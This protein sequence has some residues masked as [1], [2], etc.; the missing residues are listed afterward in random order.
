[1]CNDNNNNNNNNNNSI[2]IALLLPYDR[3]S[4]SLYS[5]KTRKLN[6]KVNSTLYQMVIMKQT[7]KANNCKANIYKIT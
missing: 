7:S 4:K 3:C 5:T 1:M 2:Y 6:T